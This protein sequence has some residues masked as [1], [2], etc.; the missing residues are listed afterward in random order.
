MKARVRIDFACNDPDNGQFDGKALMASYGDVEIE[1]PGWQP[2]AFTDLGGAIRIH[3]K[4]FPY[5]DSKDW[6]GNWCWNGYWFER[7]VA[8]RLLVTLRDN[9][10]RA[11]CAPVR[12]YDWF[13]R[14]GHFA[15]ALQAA[16]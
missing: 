12:F 14:E 7:S 4:R 15:P 13:N 1:G 9:G 6:I 11:T 8:K 5:V 16:E 2:F 10:W 3:R